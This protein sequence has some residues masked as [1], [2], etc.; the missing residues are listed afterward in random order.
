MAHGG[1]KKAARNHLA[2]FNATTGNLLAWNPN[3]DDSVRS[4]ASAVNGTVIFAGGDFRHVG[5][6][7]HSRVVKLNAGGAGKPIKWGASANGDR[8]HGQGGE[9][10]AV[11][12]WRLH[13]GQQPCARPPGGRRCCRR[14]DPDVGAAGQRRRPSGAAGR[15]REC[16]SAVTS[17]TVNGKA[18]QHLVVV[19]GKTRRVAAVGI[20]PRRRS[21]RPAGHDQASVRGRLRRRRPCP[22][23]RRQARASAVDQHHRRQRRGPR[24]DRQAT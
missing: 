12:G 8:A 11:H 20:A 21:K 6:G 3:A 1:G 23:L 16:S 24:A 10:Q 5:G 19:D 9:Q 4:L 17:L 7:T 22:C 15:L 13:L 14:R 2:A 18:Q